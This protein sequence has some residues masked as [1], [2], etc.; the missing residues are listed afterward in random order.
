MHVLIAADKFKDSLTAGQAC[1]AIAAGLKRAQPEWIADVCP[2]TDGGEGFARILT[3]AAKGEWVPMKVTGPR[4]KPIEAGFGVVEAVCLPA[5]V[6]RRIGWS[7]A[8]RL[9]VIEMAAAS[10]LALLR[11]DERDVWQT[12]TGGT[13]ELIAAADDKRVDGILLGVGGS[14]THDLGLGALTALGLELLDADGRRVSGAA[15]RF[16]EQVAR[17]EAGRLR[18]LPPI[19]I[20]CDVTNPLLGSR[21]AATVYGPQKGLRPEA[22][23]RLEAESARMAALVCASRGVAME[24]EQTSGA[25]AAGGIA[26]G[27]MAVADARLVSGFELVVDWLRIEQRLAA[28]DLVITGEGRFDESSVQGKGPGSLVRAALALGKPVHVFAGRV[29]AVETSGMRLH[30]ITPRGV[31]LAQALAKA[32]PWLQESAA[33]AFT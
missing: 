22:L 12:H 26:F 33:A 17:V 11:P 15:P 16:W 28:A 1:E 19:W 18:K 14:A 31:P 30:E 3:E 20:A 10:G 9:A 24:L 13:G 2:L 23:P 5:A 32:G 6:L 8:G 4:G 7:G 25:G 21:G 29:D 27:L